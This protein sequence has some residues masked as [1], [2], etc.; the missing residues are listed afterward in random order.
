MS[1]CCLLV[2]VLYWARVCNKHFFGFLQHLLLLLV[3]MYLLGKYFFE[4]ITSAKLSK[5]STI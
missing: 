5:L 1:V 3:T 2:F 4:H